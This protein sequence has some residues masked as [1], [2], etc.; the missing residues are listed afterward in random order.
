MAGLQDFA[1][2]TLLVALPVMNLTAATTETSAVVALGA[3]ALI[4]AYWEV[5][6]SDA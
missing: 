5:F 3:A 6:R 4:E 1:V 2:H